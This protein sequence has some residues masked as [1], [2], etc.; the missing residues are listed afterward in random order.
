M[1]E[2][3]I[4]NGN[5]PRVAPYE[6]GN[7]VELGTM[8]HE[9]GL[10]ALEARGVI[11][12]IQALVNATVLAAVPKMMARVQTA[13]RERMAILAHRVRMQTTVMG[14]VSRD[15][16]LAMIAQTTMETPRTGL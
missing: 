7:L 10:G 1:T 16:V 11:E 3:E 14:W 15:T 9:M 13:H 8:L 2:V 6:Q 12:E 5:M 4:V